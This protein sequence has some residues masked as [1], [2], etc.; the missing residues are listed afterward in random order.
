MEYNFDR[1]RKLAGLIKENY[2]PDSEETSMSKQYTKSALR[3]HVREQ[4]LAELEEAKKKKSTPEP[5]LEL[6]SDLPSEEAPISEP[7][8]GGDVLEMQRIL[9]QAYDA[10]AQMGDQ[11]LVDQ[12]GNTITFFTRTHVLDKSEF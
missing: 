8:T 10:A 7:S 3:K 1:M 9:K 2:S 6:P 11:K 4:I 12:I 5:E